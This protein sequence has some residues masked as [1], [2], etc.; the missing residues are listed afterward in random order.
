MRF[1]WSDNYEPP[2]FICQTNLRPVFAEEGGKQRQRKAVYQFRSENV[3]QVAGP[4]PEA[5]HEALPQT[6]RFCM[7]V[8]NSIAKI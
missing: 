3:F 7:G 2:Y 1:W 8:K 4:G 5:T 6:V